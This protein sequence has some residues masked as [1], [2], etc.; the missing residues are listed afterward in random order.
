M[1]LK[2]TFEKFGGRPLSQVKLNSF[3]SFLNTCGLVDLGYV[4]PPFTWTN[5]RSNGQIVRTRIDCT[6]ATSDW[7]T[8][9]HDSKVFHLPRP[10]SYHCPILLKTNN[11]ETRAPKPFHFETIWMSH[12]DFLPLVRLIW[13]QSHSDLH[14]T[15]NNFTKKNDNMEQTYLSKHL[16]KKKRTHA[17][18]AGIQ[19]SLCLHKN[20]QLLAF[21]NE[22]QETYNN[23]L[24]HEEELWI[25]KSRVNWISLGDRITIFS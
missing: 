3:N 2:K 7:I 24:K 16:L 25:L 12:K 22:L 23:L 8:L 14:E 11:F 18:L 13:N 9:F 17:R 5:G 21:E 1:T 6:H 19:R 4:G 15:I 20:S 10:R